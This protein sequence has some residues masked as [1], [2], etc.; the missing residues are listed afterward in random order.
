MIVKIQSSLLR[1]LFS[2]RIGAMELQNTEK[3]VTTQ[4]RGNTY[5]EVIQDTKVS[6]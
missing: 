4:L 5:I 3:S 2:Y 6:C 1:P